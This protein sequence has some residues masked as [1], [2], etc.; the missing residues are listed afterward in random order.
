MNIVVKSCIYYMSK[1]KKLLAR[2]YAV[3]EIKNYIYFGTKDQICYGWLKV[4][5]DNQI[6]EYITMHSKAS[7][8]L[9]CRVW[10]WLEN[11]HKI[12]SVITQK[13]SFKLNKQF[14][15]ILCIAQISYHAIIIYSN[16][17][18]LLGEKHFIDKNSIKNAIKT[19]KFWRIVIQKLRRDN[20]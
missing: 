3:I 17:E 20:K 4:V 13:S 19:L 1:N 9:Q 8:K 12:I 11:S 7:N 18:T 15:Y 16:Y 2:P 5:D 10:L 6:N 14:Y